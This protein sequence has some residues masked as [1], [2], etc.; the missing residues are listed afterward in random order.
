M[1]IKFK[2]IIVISIIFLSTLIIVWDF[3]LRAKSFDNEMNSTSI[4]KSNK[5]L[6]NEVFDWGEIEVISEPIAGQNINV[7]DSWTPKIAIENDKIYVVW[8][9][10]TDYKGAAGDLD[11]FFKYF[12]GSKWS[13]IQVISE[14]I[15][16]KNI[17]TKNSVNPDIAVENGKIYIV[18]RD[19]NDTNGAGIDREIFYRCNL[20]GKSWETEQVISEPIIGS[21]LNKVWSDYPAI[22]V[23]NDKIYVIWQDKNNTNSAAEDDDIFYRCNITGSDWE[24][25]QVISEPVQSKNFNRG[26]SH[27]PAIAVENGKIYVT[28]Q[29]TNNTNGAAIDMDIFFRC[30]HTG[31]SWENIQVISEPVPGWNFNIGNSGSPSIA[32]K[33]SKIYVVWDDNNNSNNAES[34]DDIFYRCNLIGSYWEPVQVISE[35]VQG[36]NI[37]IGDSI[38]P[39]IAVENDK[40]YVVWYDFSNT[41]GAGTDG[42]IFYRCN[43]TEVSWEDIQVISEP[44]A[45]N[46]FNTGIS[47]LP[48]ITVNLGKNHIVWQDSNDTN[49]SGFDADIFYT[50]IF[51][52]VVLGLPS[53][54][55][56]LGNTSTD[57][58][59]TVRYFHLN[60]TA[61]TKIYVNISGTDYSMLEV[62][63]ADTNY[64]NGKDYYFNI[65]NLAIGVHSYQYYASDGEFS[66][67]TPVVN[68]PRVDN[69]LPNIIT[70]DNLTAFEDV[71]YKVDYEYEDIDII[72]VGQTVYWNISTNAN[73][74]E[75]NR[76]TTVLNGT[77]TND[78]VGEYWVNITINDTMDID[79][80]NFTLTVLNINDPPVIITND[81]EIVYEDEHYEIY[82]NA[83]DID[84]PEN[85][86]IWTMDTNA[87]WL[88]FEP[89]TAVLNGTPENDDVGEYWVK[90]SVSD[91]EYMDY[92]NFTLKVINVNDPPR[93][94]TVDNITATEDELY[95]TDYDAEDVDN[96]PNELSWAITS[97]AGWLAIDSANAIINGTPENDDVGEYWVNVSVSDSEYIDFT[98]FTL[99]VI[100]TNDPPRI[101]TE[102]KTNV[103]VGELY[104]VNYEAEDIDPLPITLTWSLKTNTSNWLSLDPIT[105]LLIGIPSENNIGAYWVNI[106]VNDGE[107][108]WGNHNFTLRVIK[109]PIQE[110]NAPELSNS[111]M[112]PSQ[113]DTDT[114]FTFSVHYYDA[115]GDTPVFIQVVIDDAVYNMELK[116]GGNAAN[117]TYKY[118]TTL[119][120]GTHNYYFTAFNGLKTVRTDNSTTPYIKKV[121]V[122]EGS[123]KEF[124]WYWIIWLV[125]IMIIIT[126]IM[127]LIINKKRKA[128][129]IP[130]VK[131]EL[132]HAAPEHI[133]LPSVTSDLAGA[134]LSPQP[135]VLEQLPSPIVQVQPS[136]AS[137][138]ANEKVPVPSL[139]PA[140]VTPQYQLPQ[141]TLIKAQKLGLLEERFLISEVDLETYKELKAEIEDSI[142]A[143]ITLEEE[144]VKKKGLEEQS[145][146][147]K[148]QSEPIEEK[149][150]LEAFPSSTTEPSD[151]S[152]DQLPKETEQ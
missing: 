143:D 1:K 48:H 63:P 27:S 33:N 85:N 49:G 17:N 57:F 15:Q 142:T 133:A 67:S 36:Q 22:A 103:T 124:I 106:S 11:I 89:T 20:T 95:E 14:P 105:G 136:D 44:V 2:S 76:I 96:T 83:F 54:T 82:Y 131:A 139:T 137:T 7:E 8:V 117:G 34:D 35:P 118:S 94:V 72:N 119:A 121:D 9:D 25:I 149:T 60:N 93:I 23:E 130:I 81:T 150:K 147:G 100:N 47:A 21:D 46:N 38:R 152:T 125:I 97:N 40:I 140:P 28:W 51:S 87:G 78:N 108:G 39:E 122:N 68:K 138:A 3:D 141:A 16:G 41:S 90:I 26:V 146:I 86:L 74:L 43:F 65:K 128:A 71:Y 104:S 101:I 32:V 75:F 151:K 73:W 88:N 145:T 42:E 29:D 19:Q 92:S 64:L 129:K 110:N 84:T 116:P 77:P 37:S 144:E 135:T 113:G 112:T 70:E 148:K 55:P 6:T 126:L 30:N 123:K 132:L 5:R 120:E 31:T 13:E 111:S 56:T 52:P 102:D 4:S 10:A 66:W 18:W 98:N 59:F 58:N 62:D 114:V 107:N 53:V 50:Y 80:T 79:F 99:T 91:S 127:T 45:G 24:N 12:D 134:S 69:T 61:P 109:E 115:D